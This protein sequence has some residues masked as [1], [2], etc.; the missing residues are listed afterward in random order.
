MNP[1]T[2]RCAAAASSANVPLPQNSA[3]S[4][5]ARH[6]QQLHL[7]DGLELGVVTELP[8]D[9]LAGGHLEELGLF[10]DVSVSE[11]TREDGVAVGQALAAAIR[12]SGFRAD[13]FR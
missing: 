7:V 4:D 3:P 12:R 13:H 6:I 5:V 10:P 1:E 9:L 2:L 11:V 8:D